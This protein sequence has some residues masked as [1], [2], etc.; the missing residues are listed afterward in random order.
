MDGVPDLSSRVRPPHVLLA[1][2]AVLLVTGAVAPLGEGGAGTRAALLAAAVAT[3]AGSVWASGV[4]LR[5]T[6]ETLAATA[7]VL[8]AVAVHDGGPVLTGDPWGPALL[9]LALVV[10]ARAQPGSPTWPL[11]AWGLGQ[12]A[13][14]R[15]VADVPEGVGRTCVLLTV[16]LIGLAVVLGARRALARI[17]LLTTVPWWV[18]GV[19]GGLGT[20]W[21]DEG[22]AAWSSAG[23]T[24]AAAAGLLV[25]RLERDVDPLLGPPR[26]VPV[27]AGL[28][29]GAAVA[30]ALPTGPAGEVAAGYAGVLLATTAAAVLRGWP[31][32]LLL[33]PATAAGTTLVAYAV[34]RLAASGSWSALVLLLLLTAVPAALVGWARRDERPAAVPAALGCLGAAALLAVPADLL[35]PAGAAVALTA[36][37]GAA[38]AGS[39]TSADHTRRHTTAVGAFAA[40]AAVVLVATD[41]SGGQLAGHLATQGALTSLWAAR[42]GGTTGAAPVADH[43]G[44]ARGRAIGAAQLVAA[45]WTAAALGGLEVLEAWTLPAAA[46]LLLAAG[47]RLRTGP[48]WP[49]WGPGLLVAALPSTVL[50]VVEPGAQRPLLVLGVAAAVLVGGA[51]AALRTPLLVGAGTAVALAVGLGVTALPLPLAGALLA[52]TALLVL[53]AR[54]ELRPVGG[55]A[56]RLADMR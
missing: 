28:V 1:V 40:A 46:G 53:G 37:Y 7:V 48:S 5:G 16:A 21:A 4:G 51:A 39:A 10:V 24:V 25:V 2:G 27:L 42:R 9:A 44:A 18:A 15:A 23:L 55:F 49:A 29:A 45:A 32:G 8:A 47:P 17:A 12:L 35:D 52:G 13:A 38:L 11:G 22:P 20:A 34:A 54:R 43:S 6:R 14:L 33:P 3:G 26:A 19:A 36:V 30:G 50:A 56:A 41:G 31:R